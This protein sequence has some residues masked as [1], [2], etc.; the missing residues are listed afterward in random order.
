MPGGLAALLPHGVLRSGVAY[1]VENSTSLIMAVLAAATADGGWAAVVGLPDFG[2]EAAEGFGIDLERTVFVP[3]PGEHWLAVTAA[4][5]DVLP[6]VVV[7]PERAVGAA[8]VARVGAR[9][10]QTGCTL[11]VAGAWPQSEA[12]LRV[13]GTS[14]QGLGDGHGFVCGRDLTVSVTDRGGPRQAAPLHL[15]DSPLTGT[16]GRPADA[17]W[18]ETGTGRRPVAG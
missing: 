18:A 12:A 17:V 13:T 15:P 6:V 1:T 14:W 8:E 3:N 5:V 16:A 11:V 2:A 9:L 10:R 7:H 4:L